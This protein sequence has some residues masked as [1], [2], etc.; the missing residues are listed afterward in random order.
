MS[1]PSALSFTINAA[2]ASKLAYTSATNSATAGVNS[3]SI[4]AT[5][6][7]QFG[8][9]A[10]RAGDITITPSSSSGSG[11]KAFKTTGGSSQ[12]SYTITA[13]TSSASFLYY[14]E[15]S[16]TYNLTLSNNATSPHPQQPERAQLHDQRG[17]RR[18]LAYTLR[19]QPPTA[20]VN[21][22]S[23]TATIQ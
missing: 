8:N 23:I 9:S 13:G 10:T 1:N 11:T 18:K 17:R 14:D 6:Q 20:G 15:T 4:T 3:A 2:A 12:A 16:G 7:D 19:D 22:A 5:I 21:S